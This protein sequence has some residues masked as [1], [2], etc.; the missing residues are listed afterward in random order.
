MN[1]KIKVIFFIVI[2]FALVFIITKS[3]RNTSTQPPLE[4]LDRSS[5][6][7]KVAVIFDDLGESMRDMT[8]IYALDIPVT[9]SVIPGLKF[10]KNIAHIASRCGYTVFI[11]LPISPKN[12][13]EYKTDKYK[14]LSPLM[15]EKQVRLLTKYYLEYIRIASGVNNHMGSLGTTDPVLMKTIL[16]E[17]KKKNLI[18]VDSKTTPDSVAFG[19]AKSMDIPAAENS[20]FLDDSSD[21]E[22]IRQQISKMLDLAKAKGKMVVI[23]HPRPNTFNILKAEINGLKDKVDFVNMQDYLEK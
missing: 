18:F 17:V 21:T 19:I 10:A 14:F 20:L 9:V 23:A 4:L 1:N 2:L 3:H 5:D 7:P 8:E 13:D 6:K 15:K 16:S 22:L 11:H 12:E